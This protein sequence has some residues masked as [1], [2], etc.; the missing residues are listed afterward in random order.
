MGW[1]EKERYGRRKMITADERDSSRGTGQLDVSVS[2]LV[3]TAAAAS[4]LLFRN[5]FPFLVQPCGHHEP[6]L[7]KQSLPRLLYI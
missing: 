3:S 7:S 2:V 1:R 4:P 6:I 5:H